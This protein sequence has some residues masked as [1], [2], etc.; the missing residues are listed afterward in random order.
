MR[1]PHCAGEIS[2]DSR[3]CGICGRRLDGP[4]PAPAPTPAPTGV[5][6]APGPYN[7]D[8]GSSMSLFELP[9]SRGARVARIAI[10]IA[11]DLVLVGAGIAMIVSY[12]NARDRATGATVV[13]PPD[14]GVGQATIEDSTPTPVAGRQ[15]PSADEPPSRGPGQPAGRDPAPSRPDPTPS[16]PDPTS[17][18]P[19]PPPPRPD[20]APARPDPRPPAPDPTPP[21]VTE[22]PDDPDPDPP[23]E[24]PVDPYDDPPTGEPTDQEMEIFTGR[25]SL[26]FKA[27]RA[28]MERCYEQ[29][30]KLSQTDDPLRGAIDVRF[31]VDQG[32]KARDVRAVSNNTGS[33]QLAQCV[34]ALVSSW[35]FPLAPGSQPIDLMWPFRFSPP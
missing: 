33:Q 5:A 30:A 34:T 17:P 25:V 29:A 7:A 31:K 4:A 22:P 6:P 11:L 23:G 14:A 18:R 24:G 19:D 13:A 10:V 12:L 26:V 8:G 15:P 2:D 9:V 3:F 32:G 20:P 28:Q 35:D 21:P 1:C 27:H 16:R